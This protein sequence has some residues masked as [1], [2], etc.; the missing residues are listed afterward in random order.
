MAKDEE[1]ELLEGDEVDDH[2]AETQLDATKAVEM[3][4]FPKTVSNYVFLMK[5]YANNL[6]QVN[7]SI[8]RMWHRIV[9]VGDGR[10][11][12]IMYQ[13]STMNAFHKV[14]SDQYVLE[15]PRQDLKSLHA[16]NT[17]ISS[18]NYFLLIT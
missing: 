6:P 8:V 12:P 18:K 11:L 13:L 3:F 2:R 17:H 14:L 10:N 15:S 4:A 7:H 5:D 9:T 1:E 16:L